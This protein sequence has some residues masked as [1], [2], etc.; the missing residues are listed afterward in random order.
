MSYLFL[1]EDL[2]VLDKKI[3]ENKQRMQEALKRIGNS[4]K[5]ASDTFHDNFAFEQAQR[6]AEIWSKRVRELIL[7]RN[8][9]EVVYPTDFKDG[10]V[11]IG[12]IVVIKDEDTDQ[13]REFQVGSYMILDEERNA[14]S[15]NSPI[16]QFIIGAVIGEIR[17]GVIVGKK[18]KFKII[19]IK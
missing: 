8:N 2:E 4:C 11:N 7:I 3:E 18:K 19:K 6:D 14:I 9:V 12:R 13:T 5:E 10:R 1:L 17:E 15:Y 16:A